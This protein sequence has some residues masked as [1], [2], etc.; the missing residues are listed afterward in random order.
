MAIEKTQSDEKTEKFI[1]EEMEKFEAMNGVA[2]NF[3]PFCFVAR[4]NAEMVGA[5]TGFLSFSEVYIDEMV[6]FVT[7]PAEG[8][9]AKR[10]F[11]SM[12]FLL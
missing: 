4:E 2:C 6:V 3:T 10:K 8:H 5:L 12:P 11:C 9:T 7:E 1:E